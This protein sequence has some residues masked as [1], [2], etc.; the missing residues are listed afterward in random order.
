[1]SEVQRRARWAGIFSRD[2]VTFAGGWYLIIYQGQFAQTFNATVFIGG[3]LIALVPGTLAAWAMRQLPGGL[4]ATEPPSSAPA[5]E[6][7]SPPP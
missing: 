2:T 5:P 4:P 1:M 7:P 6:L 3:I